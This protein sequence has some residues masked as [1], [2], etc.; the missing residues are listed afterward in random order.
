MKRLQVPHLSQLNNQLNPLGSCNVTCLAMV[1]RYYGET[2][3]TPDRLYRW[4]VTRSLSRHSGYDLAYTFNQF[5]KKATDNFSTT[6][7]LESI[8]VDIDNGNPS[9]IH[10][11]FTI[12]GHIVVVTGYDAEGFFVN[13]PY[14]EWFRTGYRNDLTGKG[15]HYSNDLIVKPCYYDGS[16]W[17]HRFTPHAN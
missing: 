7:D 13:D 17:H 16:L 4:M 5:A 11:Y 9:I 12:F 15:L 6:S 10:G 8:R 1:L 14:G 3:V 2:D